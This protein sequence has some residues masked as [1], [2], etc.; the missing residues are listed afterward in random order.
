[1]AA[2]GDWLE[3]L[4]IRRTSKMIVWCDFTGRVMGLERNPEHKIA[5]IRNE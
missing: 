3:G 1:M 4:E 5:G 2:C